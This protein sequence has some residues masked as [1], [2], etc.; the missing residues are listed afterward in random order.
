MVYDVTKQQTFE[1]IER[2][3]K[4]LKAN[5]EPNI[6]LMLV[7]NKVDLCDEDPSKREVD[8]AEAEKF[9]ETHKMLFI[10]TSAFADKNVK[11]AFEQLLQS[12]FPYPLVIS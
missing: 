10:E 3:V 8:Q 11:D 5:A 4:E 6:V 12:T 9:A 1:N 7:G 2:W